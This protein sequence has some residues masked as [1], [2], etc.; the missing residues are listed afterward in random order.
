MSLQLNKRY[1]KYFF[2]PVAE[3]FEEGFWEAIKR[4]ELVFQ[5]CGRCGVWLHP[6][7]P[8]CHRCKS[9]DLRWEKSAG[10]GKIYSWVT[11]TRE[12]NPLYVV[13]FEVVLVEMEGE[14]G[15][16]MV[17]NMVDCKPEEIHIGMPV[18][19]DFVD[20]TPEQPLPVF[21]R[22]EG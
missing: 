19:L 3:S 8:M 21:R 5:R 2:D 15:V 6:P 17:S 18:E 1:L 4:R 9:F 22:R 12:V 10:R 16:R 14:E 11:F 7:R 13:P 20:V